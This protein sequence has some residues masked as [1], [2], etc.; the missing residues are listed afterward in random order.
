MQTIYSDIS[1]PRILAT[2]ALSK[3][4]KGAYLSRI[5]SVT[6]A[7]QP[8]P[9]LPGPN[10]VR[11]RNRVSLICGTDIHF[12]KAEGDPRIAPAALPSTQ[13]MY[14]GHEIC[15]QVLEVGSEV[16]HLSPGDR[17]VLRYPLNFCHIQGIDPP[18]QY[19]AKG[20][21][22]LC[23]NQAE[24]KEPA[25]IGGGWSDQF[26]AHQLHLYRPPE[27][28]SDEEISLIEPTSCGLHI[29]LRAMPQPQDKVMVLGCGSMGLMVIR[30]LHALA[31]E[32]N[33][34]AVARYPFQAEAARK[35]GAD[36]AHVG[37]DVYEVT[38]DATGAKLYRG[39]M[40]GAMLLGGFDIVYDC[41][42]IGS[43][44]TDALRCARAEGLVV[45]VGNQFELL[46][47]DMTPLW[48]QEVRLVAPM[49]HGMEQWQGETVETYELA[50]RLFQ[51]GDL[52]SD[53]IITHR[54]HLSQWREAVK[55][56]MDKR[57][58]QSIKVAF[59][60]E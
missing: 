39:K 54:F 59:V 55:A 22:K 29:V 36:E 53:G 34:T 19:C 18:C 42:G 31:P 30:A 8:D 49:A 52:M 33:V 3:L 40:G 21:W 5:S 26:I 16:T 15:G 25:T 10:H 23:E 35:F 50:A 41:I 11:V 43:T 28:L 57:K 44:L 32:S 2:R 56:A 45:L 38:A 27:K 20:E 4:W 47:V 51:S 12:V 7:D 37:K 58:H 48:F 9:P 60:F 13:R 14:L 46:K 6:F 1:V 24:S 17:V